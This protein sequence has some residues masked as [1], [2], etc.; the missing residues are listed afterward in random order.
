MKR[1]DCGSVARPN[2]MVK[3]P[4]TA[5]GMEAIETLIAEGINVN[6]TLLFARSMYERTAEAYIAG[7]ERRVK[8]GES[9]SSVASVAVSSLAGLIRPSINS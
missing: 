9:I 2:L 4:G 6:V 5:E 8:A 7:L 1:E 3:V